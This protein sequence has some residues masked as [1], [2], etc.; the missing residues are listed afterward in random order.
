MNALLLGL[1]ASIAAFSAS[2]VH[3]TAGDTGSAREIRLL[4]LAVNQH[5]AAIGCKPLIWDERL[6]RL[7]RNYSKSMA[8]KRFFGHI[9]PDGNDPFDRMRHAGI[10]YRAA[11]ENLAAGQTKGIQVYGD[12]MNSPGHRKVIENSVYTHYGIGFYR[13]RWSYLSARY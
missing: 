2:A 8:T 7:A 5:R 4:M 10:R 6:A 13:N 9:D 11:G 12:W 1:I 3:V